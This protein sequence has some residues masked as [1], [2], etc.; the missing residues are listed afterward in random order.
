[1]DA[2]RSAS[3]AVSGAWPK[4]IS[5]LKSMVEIAST[6]LHYPYRKGSGPLIERGTLALLVGA[7]VSSII[8]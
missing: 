1:M 7:H 2:N 3:I 5:S 6:V 8:H 4:V